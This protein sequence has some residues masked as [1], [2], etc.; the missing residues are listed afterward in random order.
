MEEELERARESAR[1]LKE[2]FGKRVPSAAEAASWRSSLCCLAASAPDFGLVQELVEVAGVRPAFGADPV[3]VVDAILASEVA[4][5]PPPPPEPLTEQQ[6]LEA[7]LAARLAAAEAKAAAE[8]AAREEER[9]EDRELK[10]ALLAGIQE[11]RGEV[12]ASRAESAAARAE[13]E[14]LKAELS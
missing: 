5:R 10:Q 9:K 11:L 3:E 8:A 12:T 14:K 6:Q 7:R 1:S 4:K 2:C 13:S